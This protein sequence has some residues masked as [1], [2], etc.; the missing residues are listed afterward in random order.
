MN[1]RISGILVFL[2][3]ILFA[4]Q[5]QL[6]QSASH[7]E[8][9]NQ[10][11]TRVTS[12]SIGNSNKG[13]GYTT[14]EVIY[15][16]EIWN[17]YDTS[18]EIQHSNTCK[19]HLVIDP[20]TISDGTRIYNSIACGEA[21]T[22]VNYSPGLTIISGNTE[23]LIEDSS[24]DSLPDG[25][26]ELTLGDPNSWSYKDDVSFVKAFMNLSNGVVEFSSD[27]VP[28]YWNVITDSPDTKSRSLEVNFPSI[29][30]SLSSFGLFI[31]V[32]RRSN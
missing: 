17:R 22:H 6:A 2:I 23:L 32:K 9:D 16:A 5:I 24:I 26:Y 8:V 20:P 18:I 30:L 7:P 25:S 1:Y 19:F 4:T 15:E 28:T 12:V 31:L 14:F 21:I 29:V 10:L 13:T 3:L 11:T 27:K